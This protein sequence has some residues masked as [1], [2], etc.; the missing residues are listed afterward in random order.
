MP[1]ETDY[2]QP[3]RRRYT[4]DRGDTPP[5]KEMKIKS[6]H[7]LVLIIAIIIDEAHWESGIGPAG[8]TA[9]RAKTFGEGGLNSLAIATNEN[10]YQCKKNKRERIRTKKNN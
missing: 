5:P 6:F 3:Q 1:S 9:P 10:A 8:H 7:R 2:T 4:V